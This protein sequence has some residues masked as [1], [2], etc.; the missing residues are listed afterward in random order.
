METQTKIITVLADIK[1]CIAQGN[2]YHIIK[3]HNFIFDE[4]VI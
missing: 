2:N 4:A 1:G 3:K